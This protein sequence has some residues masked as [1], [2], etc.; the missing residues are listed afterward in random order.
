[1][2]HQFFGGHP[3]IRVSFRKAF[4]IERND[5]LPWVSRTYSPQVF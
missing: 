3:A 2:Q 5:D 4:D 1:M